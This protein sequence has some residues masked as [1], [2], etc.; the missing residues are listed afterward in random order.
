M[1]ELLYTEETYRTIYDKLQLILNKGIK[2]NGFKK[3]YEAIS[4]VSAMFSVVMDSH[5]INKLIALCSQG[6][7]GDDIISWLDW[8]KLKSSS[9][10]I[11]SLGVSKKFLKAFYDYQYEYMKRE[12]VDSMNDIDHSGA[13]ISEEKLNLV[14]YILSTLLIHSKK[15][16]YTEF[17]IPVAVVM[18]GIGLV[19]LIAMLYA[20]LYI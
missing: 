16:S 4:F 1:N 19:S 20:W 13:F 18:Y 17:K 6:T 11:E 12:W 14:C 5:G 8:L 9:N 7:S 15:I 10:A 3:E 2:Q